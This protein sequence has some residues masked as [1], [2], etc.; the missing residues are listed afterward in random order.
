MKLILNRYVLLALINAI[1][2]YS[3]I[4]HN[5]YFCIFLSI[6]A[7]SEQHYHARALYISSVIQKTQFINVV[8]LEE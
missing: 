5:I 7:I 1:C 3:V 4:L 6:S 2:K 8:M